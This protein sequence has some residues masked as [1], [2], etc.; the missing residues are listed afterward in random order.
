LATKFRNR[1]YYVKD[2]PFAGS[3]ADVSY[4]SAAT[5]AVV[6]YVASATN[7]HIIYS[8]AYSYSA[9]PT[10]GRLTVEDGSGTYIFDQNISA[11]GNGLIEFPGGLQGSTNTAMIIT[12]S[13]GAGAVV[14]KLNVLG[15]GIN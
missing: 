6:T 13:S 15:H 8:I 12:L 1:L 14:G 9:A 11:T 2:S 7:R 5:A 3:S 4:P 10:G